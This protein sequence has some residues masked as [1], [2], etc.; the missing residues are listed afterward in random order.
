MS[1][2]F[3]SKTR[4]WKAPSAAIHFACRTIYLPILSQIFHFFAYLMPILR[5]TV[6]ITILWPSLIVLASFSISIHILKNYHFSVKIKKKSKWFFLSGN[7]T[8]K[9]EKLLESKKCAPP[10]NFNSYRLV[11]S[12]SILVLCIEQ[13]L[14]FKTC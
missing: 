9:I 1:L 11:C 8:G 6:P 12:T 2:Y 13:F 5:L 7:F 4:L 10:S 14:S 3:F